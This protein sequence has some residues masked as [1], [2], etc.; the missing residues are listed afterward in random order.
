MRIHA[1]RCGPRHV[2][3]STVTLIAADDLASAGPEV[4]PVCGDE[5]QEWGLG[6]KICT[7]QDGAA[8]ASG[9]SARTSQLPWPTRIEGASSSRRRRTIRC[10]DA[11]IHPPLAYNTRGRPK[12]TLLGAAGCDSNDGPKSKATS[13]VEAPQPLVRSACGD[14]GPGRASLLLAMRRS[15]R[16]QGT[17]CVHCGSSCFQRAARLLRALRLASRRVAFARDASLLSLLC[18]AALRS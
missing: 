12:A 4:S 7:G 18:F 3:R 8:T 10:F 13:R 16:A 2:S 15:V 6:A 5:G 17:A 1:M 14:P 11:S 9:I